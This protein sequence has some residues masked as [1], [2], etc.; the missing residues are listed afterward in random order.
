M[1]DSIKA[2]GDYLTLERLFSAHTVLAYL[3]DV[4]AFS[5]FL[6]DLQLPPAAEVD[7]GPV[8]SWMVVLVNSGCSHR[9]VNRKMASLKA[10]YLFLRKS[11]QISINPMQAHRSLKVARKVQVPFSQAEVAEW[12]SKNDFSNDF[13]GLR[14]RLIVEL[15]YATGVRRAEL[16]LLK[17]ADVDVNGLLIKVLGKRNKERVIPMLPVLV[18]LI[19]AY[20]AERNALEAADKAEWFFVSEKG[21]KLSESFVYRLVNGYFSAVTQKVKRSPH[22]LRHTFATHLLNNGADMNSVKELLGHSSLASTQVYTHSSLAEL[23]KVYVAAHP[24]NRDSSSK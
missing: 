24:R 12:L 5:Q 10:Y 23:Q 17:C 11:G 7:Y 21:V 15:L 18:P 16:I 8:R 6:E 2:F 1:S 13:K 14:N 20:I 19:R 3:A 9:T 4:R 22:M